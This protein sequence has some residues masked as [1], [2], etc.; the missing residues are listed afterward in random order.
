MGFNEEKARKN[1]EAYLNQN[2]FDTDTDLTAQ[3]NQLL[4][5]YSE[6]ADVTQKYTERVSDEGEVMEYTR[7]AESKQWVKEHRKAAYEAREIHSEI[8]E[9]LEEMDRE[10]LEEKEMEYV[11]D[12]TNRRQIKF[13]DHDA[14]AEKLGEDVAVI[15]SQTFLLSSAV[16]NTDN[17]DDS[18]DGVMSKISSIFSR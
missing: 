1:F 2:S 13:I 6:I 11:W 4:N 10:L 18:K 9:L 16:V 3:F 5:R 14:V 15:T 12:E 17:E 7:S 8:R